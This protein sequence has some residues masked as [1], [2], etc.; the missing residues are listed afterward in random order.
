MTERARPSL[1]I[2]A[3]RSPVTA[4]QEVADAAPSL[5]SS[6]RPYSALLPLSLSIAP[7]EIFSTHDDQTHGLLIIPLGKREKRRE[8]YRG[9]GGN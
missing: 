6:H 5:S 1:A 4:K 8:E 2:K 3:L 9:G 7:G